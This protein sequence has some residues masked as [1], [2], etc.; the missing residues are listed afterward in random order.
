MKLYAII[1]RENAKPVAFSDDSEI[2]K[3]FFYQQKFTGEEYWYG[4]IKK[5][6]ANEI[7]GTR[8][9]A[10]LYLVKVGRA[11]IQSKYY[12]E[13]SLL[14]DDAVYAYDEVLR[15]LE[16]ELECSDLSKQEAKAMREVIK[17]LDKKIESLKEESVPEDTLK[18]LKNDLAEYR[19]AKQKYDF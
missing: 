3:D 14:Q 17:Y 6:D 8:D 1:K 15:T 7:R 18:S 2:I 10:D 5:R 12:D 4:K 19:Y 16:T 11:W 9:Y 13:M